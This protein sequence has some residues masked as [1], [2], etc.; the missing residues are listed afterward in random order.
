LEEEIKKDIQIYKEKKV[1]QTKNAAWQ[2]LSEESKKAYTYDYKLFFDFAGKD[3]LDITASDI[4]KFIEHLEDNNYKNSS[5]NR[6][7]CS[8]SKMFRVMVIAGEI[9]TNPI[10][11]LKQF[12][13]ITY[14]TSRNIILGI[15]IQDIKKAVKILKN[16]TLQDKKMILIIRAL[17]M[18]GL[19][20]SEFRNIQNNNISDFDEANQVVDIVG[21]G[22]KE[23][24]IYIPNK[25][26]EEIRELYPLRE[27]VPYL[28]YTIRGNQYDRKALWKQIK[29]FFIKRIGKHVHPHMLRHF[30]AT[31]KIHVEK[32]DIKAVS[33]F[34]GHSD[35]SIT[36]NAYVDTA[37]DVKNAKIKI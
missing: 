5:I 18:T 33:K 30:Y 16:T 8:L 25:F 3:P 4:L 10:E 17:A 22:K 23:R 21:K 37:L 1:T 15:T 7:I 6:K 13:N 31:Y 2:S 32:Q 12:R 34:L 11:D 36:L 14:K 9:K 20:I 19:R 35:V 24:R 29:N 27:N 26:I 28:F